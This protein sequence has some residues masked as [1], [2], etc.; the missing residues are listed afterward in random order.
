MAVEVEG[1]PARWNAKGPDAAGSHPPSCQGLG[2][3]R[4]LFMMAE[5]ARMKTHNRFIVSCLICLGV[6]LAGEVKA[7]CYQTP[8]G[9]SPGQV[10]LFS[11]LRELNKA[12]AT[13]NGVEL[14]IDQS[15][16]GHSAKLCNE[17]AQKA[18]FM[19]HHVRKTGQWRCDTVCGDAAVESG[20][21]NGIMKIRRLAKTCE[22]SSTRY[23][24]C[25][26]AAK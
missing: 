12:S 9:H 1:G 24:L 18:D 17:P 10:D 25:H 19:S 23:E 14:F 26:W 7:L 20:L 5:H 15:G 2:K 8:G 22:G 3:L 11:W 4:Q 16:Q 6:L 13:A 21:R